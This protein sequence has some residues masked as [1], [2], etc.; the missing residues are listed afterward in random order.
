MSCDIT[1]R[2]S[3]FPRR[4]DAYL[5]QAEELQFPLLTSECFGVQNLEELYANLTDALLIAVFPL[6][7]S[8][9]YQHTQYIFDCNM[10]LN[11][12]EIY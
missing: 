2:K 11:E 9:H 6:Q 3:S 4:A 10:S 12:I 7:L 8:K 1:L 5:P